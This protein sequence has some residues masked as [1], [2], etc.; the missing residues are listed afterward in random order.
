[1]TTSNKESSLIDMIAILSN[2]FEL[3][4][5]EIESLKSSKE[6][7]KNVE[8]NKNDKHGTKSMRSESKSYDSPMLDDSFSTIN[9]GGDLNGN[10]FQYNAPTPVHARLLRR[11]I[12]QQAKLNHFENTMKRSHHIVTSP[13]LM[14]CLVKL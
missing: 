6:I 4:S 13:R 11:G 14:I 7:Q 5:Q 9:N 1:M 12:E 10:S 8:I 3:L 2:R